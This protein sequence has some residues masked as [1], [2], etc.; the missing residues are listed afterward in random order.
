[1]PARRTYHHGNLRRALL[2]AALATLKQSGDV[3]ALTMQ[4]VARRAGVSSGAPY[5]HFQDK[6]ELLAALATEGFEQLV[7]ALST[8]LAGAASPRD[9]VAGFA[10]IY[11]AFAADHAAHYRVMFLPD[12]GDR[13]R[14][15]TLHAASDRGLQL[16]VRTLADAH[17]GAPTDRLLTRAVTL[18]STCHGFAW[19]RLEGVI[20]NMPVLPALPRVEAAIV[21]EIAD[22][23]MRPL[24]TDT[25]AR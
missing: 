12:I 6:A 14:F 4:H 5:H 11:L 18:W 19:L 10:R 3:T 24:V 9:R 16:V 20:A 1:M 21:A 22:A 7:A 8:A 2:D 15:A 17:P 13:R 23:A 25:P